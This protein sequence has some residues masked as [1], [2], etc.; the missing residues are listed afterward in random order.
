MTT[1]SAT[2]RWYPFNTEQTV[3]IVGE[4]GPLVLFFIVNGIAGV[5]AG[6]WSLIISTVLS[7]IL[8]MVM[9][10]RPPI[11]PFIAGGVSIAF[12]FIALYTGDAMWVQIKV[13]IFNSLV[14]LMLW[15][16][17]KTD[18]NFFHFVFGKTFHYTPEGWSKLTRN[19]AWF[20]L[21]TAAIN[22]AVRL[23]FNG[24]EIWTNNHVFTGIDIWVLF[25]LFV[26]MPL[27]ALFFWWQVRIM[28]QYRLP[29]PSPARVQ[30]PTST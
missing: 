2:K 10:G 7:L 11:M 22:E 30:K 18:R 24:V 26:V 27:T 9:L 8:S 6:T 14:A 25:K 15:L 17:L 23:G 21:F 1:T 28:Q 19:V 29:E 13:T 12:G 5:T 16:G 20:F 4:I 3:N